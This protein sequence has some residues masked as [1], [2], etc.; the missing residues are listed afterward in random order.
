MYRSFSRVTNHHRSIDMQP[1]ATNHNAM[2]FLFIFTSLVSISRRQD[3]DAAINSKTEFDIYLP[4]LT[5][6]S[7]IVVRIAHKMSAW[8][9]NGSARS[10]ETLLRRVERN[11]PG[12]TELVILPMKKFGSEEI[13]RLAKCLG[14]SQSKNLR[15]LQASGHA[16]EDLSALEA[17]GKVLTHIESIAIGDSK[18]G[19]DAVCALCR[20]MEANEETKDGR[21]ALKSIDLSLKSM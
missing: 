19:D 15:S 2:L 21:N 5:F 18:M 14:S 4:V 13:F 7:N 8:G 12:L 16:I 1:K 3:I 17:L 6:E 20:G 10:C 11:D 9:K